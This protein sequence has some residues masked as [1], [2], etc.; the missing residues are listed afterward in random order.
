MDSSAMKKQ[1]KNWSTNLDGK[2][3]L[4][5]KNGGYDCLYF[6]FDQ[7]ERMTIDLLSYRTCRFLKV[8]PTGFRSK[9]INYADC[10]D[11]KID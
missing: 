2:N 11:F 4:E 8:I 6:K 10:Q 7:Q 3:S 9:P 5:L 1:I